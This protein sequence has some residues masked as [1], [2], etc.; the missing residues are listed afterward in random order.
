VWPVTTMLTWQ[1]D[2]G[3]GLEGARVSFAHGFRAQGRL[4]RPDF[5]ASYRLVVD[6]NGLLSRLSVTSD[7]AERERNLTMNRT[8]DGFWLLDTG[9]GGG[10]R[11]DLGGALD[12]DLEYSPL[13][14]TLPIRRLGLHRQAGEHT[15]PMAFVRLPDL[16]VQATEQSYRTVSVD[17]GGPSVV[18]FRWADF[19][20]E[21]VVDDEGLVISYPGVG[22]RLTSD[23]AAAG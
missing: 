15:L 13:F 14:N 9:G 18:E 12:V 17:D 23:Q 21:L 8:G 19:T 4:V 10:T 7:T 11:T 6:D 2:D 16:Q 5:T 1:A 3:H 20:A 22:A